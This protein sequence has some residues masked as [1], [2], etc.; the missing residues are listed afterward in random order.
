ME[1]TVD[2]CGSEVADT[3]LQLFSQ[4]QELLYSND[5]SDGDGAC[6]NVKS[7]R[8]HIP[9][10][11]PGVYYIVTDAE[12]N[13]N[14]SLSVNGRLLA[15]TGDTKALAIDVGT[16]KAGLFFPIPEIPL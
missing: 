15:Q 13:G 11:L 4:T 9:V 14:I 8:I 10:L 5:D 12:K 2:N 1:L 7:A 6:A 16:Y 3:Y